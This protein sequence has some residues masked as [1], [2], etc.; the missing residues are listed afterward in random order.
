[1]RA[2]PKAA[3]FSIIKY[4]RLVVRGARTSAA[5]R[6]VPD[7]TNYT[8][9]PNH[10]NTYFSDLI[11]I[12]ILL[13]R[14]HLWPPY[15][16]FNNRLGAIIS[17]SERLYPNPGPIPRFPANSIFT[18]HPLHHRST[19]SKSENRPWLRWQRAPTVISTIAYTNNKIRSTALWPKIH[20]VHYSHYCRQPL[21]LLH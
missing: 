10:C 15:K 4:R 6:F 17:R 3:G 9:N 13:Y 1:M 18:Y 16:D 19:I 2:Y 8:H 21:Q 20:F 7:I 12:Y 5:T 11:Q 14:S